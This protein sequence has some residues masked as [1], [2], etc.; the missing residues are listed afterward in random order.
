M[1]VIAA[2]LLVVLAASVHGLRTAGAGPRW[3]YVVATTISGGAAASIAIATVVA[4]LA[5]RDTWN[6]W[7]SGSRSSQT[8]TLWLGLVVGAGL[9]ATCCALLILGAVLRARARLNSERAR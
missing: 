1:L 9:L 7:V 5:G 4:L 2:L 8:T 6:G 3:P